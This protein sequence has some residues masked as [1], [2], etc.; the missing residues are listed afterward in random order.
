MKIASRLASVF[1]VLVITLSQSQPATAAIDTR[2]FTAFN[3]PDAV[4][5]EVLAKRLYRLDEGA[6]ERGGGRIAMHRNF[7]QIIEQNFARMGV[8]RMSR[9]LDNV[10]ENELSDLAQLYVNAISDS[11]RQPV[12]LDIMA[13]RMT[14]KELGRMSQHFGFAPLYAAVLRTAPGKALDFQFNSDVMLASPAPGLLRFG[15]QGKLNSKGGVNVN[16][17]G[18]FLDYTLYEIYL[19]FRT[20]PIGALGVRG[21]IYETITMVAGPLGTAF[22]FGYGVGTI[23]APLVEFYAP[24]LYD[25]IGGTLDVIVDRIQD[26]PNAMERGAAEGAGAI[27]FELGPIASIMQETGGD[28]QVMMDWHMFSGFGGGVGC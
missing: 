10:Q 2:A 4:S 7:P 17:A 11:G 6:S 8:M 16:G 12:L 20:S 23:V 25:A 22:G 3:A 15:K 13:A 28:F 27:S 5:R 18:G 1:A 24:S 26:A 14:G 9:F 19:S 21:A